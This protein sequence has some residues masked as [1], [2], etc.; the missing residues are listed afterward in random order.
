MR[1][2]IRGRLWDFAIDSRGVSPDANGYC[3]APH[4][5]RKRIRVRPG[6]SDAKTMEAVI[7]ECLHAGAWELDEE[8]VEEWSAD[9]ARVLS[10]LGFTR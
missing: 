8:F 1:V 4:R 5:K 10:R 9:V 2:R 7:H 6:L 3:E